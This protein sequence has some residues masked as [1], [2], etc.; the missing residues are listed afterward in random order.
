MDIEKAR[1]VLGKKFEKKSDEEIQEI[2]ARMGPLVDMAVNMFRES[3]R[4]WSELKEPKDS[5]EKWLNKKY[6]FKKVK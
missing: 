4:E 2:L 6:G 3:V 5:F 1:K